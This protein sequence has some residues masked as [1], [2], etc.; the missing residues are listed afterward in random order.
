MDDCSLNM[1]I[2]YEDLEKPELDIYI[3]GD[4]I[5][6]IQNGSKLKFR[7]KLQLGEE[8]SIGLKGEMNEIFV[9]AFGLNKMVNIT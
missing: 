9:D 6:E 1:Y 3:E 8:G 2:N 4:L 7:S 5:G